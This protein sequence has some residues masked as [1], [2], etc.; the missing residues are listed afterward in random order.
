IRYSIRVVVKRL[1]RDAIFHLNHRRTHGIVA[2][3]IVGTGIAEGD[4]ELTVPELRSCEQG[5]GSCERRSV[6]W[7]GFI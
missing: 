2:V 7:P 3:E 5:G 1:V 4:F 6:G